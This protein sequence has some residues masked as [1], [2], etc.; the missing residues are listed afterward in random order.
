MINYPPRPIPLRHSLQLLARTRPQAWLSGAF[1]IKVE[2][3]SI[4]TDDASPYARTTVA[5]STC[6]TGLAPTHAEKP[7][8]FLHDAERRGVKGQ[9]GEK[10]GTATEGL[11][12][13]RPGAELAR[14]GRG[15]QVVRRLQ[16]HVRQI[17]KTEAKGDWPRTTSRLPREANVASR[18]REML[19]RH[20]QLDP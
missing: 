13:L 17:Q 10:G 6:W 5:C 15:G 4:G 1:E 2:L 16:E 7:R 18:R 8:A 9:R 20:G 11:D 12:S 14:P 3:R 19:T